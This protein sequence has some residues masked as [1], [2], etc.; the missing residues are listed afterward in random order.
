MKDRLFDVLMPILPKNELSHWVGRLVHQPLPAPLARGSVA[1]FARYYEINLAEA[2]FPLEQYRSIG[3]L[4]TRRLKPG[5]RPIGEGAVHP[6]DAEILEAGEI[7]D[8]TL[9]Q[10]KGVEYT[11]EGLLGGG[12]FVPSFSDGEFLTYYLCPTDYHRVH[13]PVDGKVIW[14][15]HIPGQMWPVNR[16]SVRRIPNLYALNERVAAVIET[17]KGLAALVMVAATNVGNISVTFDSAI[18][19]ARRRGDRKSRQID[20]S[21][22]I[23]CKRG[24]EF[25]VFSMGSTVVMLYQKGVLPAEVK[26]GAYRRCHVKMGQSL[27]S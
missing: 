18:S 4:F 22:G 7:K 2:E 1:A 3:E 21:P 13:F 10:A 14:S 6:V 24:E 20:Y 16:W 25:G 26:A 27:R 17:P 12:R 19:T 15:S 11:V 8:Q 5:A 9:I 23:D